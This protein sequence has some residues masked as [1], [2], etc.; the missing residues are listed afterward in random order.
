MQV[1]DENDEEERGNKNEAQKG[2]WGVSK[3]DFDRTV[4]RKE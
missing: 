2:Y 3:R 1:Y 4:R